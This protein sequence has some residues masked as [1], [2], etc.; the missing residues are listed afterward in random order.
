MEIGVGC[1]FFLSSSEFLFGDDLF[2][3][4]SDLVDANR[5]FV[6]SLRFRSY[7]RQR[8]GMEVKA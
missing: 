8:M 5:S 3:T 6:K 2:Q 1:F 7:K 4:D